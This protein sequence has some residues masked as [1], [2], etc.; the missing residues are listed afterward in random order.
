[1]LLD[2]RSVPEQ[3]FPPRVLRWIGALAIAVLA[4]AI[5]GILV[6]SAGLFDPFPAHLDVTPRTPD[7]LPVPA[8]ATVRRW[9]GALPPG[10]VADVRLAATAAREPVAYGLLLGG[11]ER[12]LAAAVSSEG[13]LAIW[14]DEGGD[15]TAL[16]PWQTWPHVRPGGAENEIRLGRDGDRVSVWVNRERLWEGVI[17]G[18]G[19]QVGVVAIAPAGPAEARFT[20]LELWPDPASEP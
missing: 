14:V 4:I 3:A 18:L 13:Y 20:R 8:G 9:E 17:S 15:E 5:A 11:P 2:S 16:L 12:A 1:M 6:I 7:P 10:G 19:D